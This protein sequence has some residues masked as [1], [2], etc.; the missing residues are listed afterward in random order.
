MTHE[1]AH[2]VILRVYFGAQNNDK[3]TVMI[4]LR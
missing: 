4:M 2:Y 1:S 3:M